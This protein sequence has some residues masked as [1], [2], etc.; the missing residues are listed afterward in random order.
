MTE[1]ITSSGPAV[2][3]ERVRLHG[4]QAAALE[5]EGRER[6]VPVRDE[7][8]ALAEGLAGRLGITS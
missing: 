7:E 5:R 4:G 8:W 3:F 2:G 6:G 1:T